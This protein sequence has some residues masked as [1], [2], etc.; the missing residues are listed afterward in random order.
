MIASSSSFI[1]AYLTYELIFPEE[2][3]EW[4]S[5]HDKA[6]FAVLDCQL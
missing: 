3:F 2:S 6:E 1:A 4:N 5:E